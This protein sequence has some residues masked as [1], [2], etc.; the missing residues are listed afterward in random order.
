MS[1]TDFVNML[2]KHFPV[3]GQPLTIARHAGKRSHWLLNDNEALYNA[4]PDSRYGPKDIVYQFNSLG[5]RTDEFDQRRDV[6]VIVG[7]CSF[8]VGI[9]LPLEQTYPFILR[10]LLQ[11]EL[12]TSV[13]VWN[14]AAAAWG[15]D[16]IARIMMAA[17]KALKP[18]M[19]YV[20]WTDSSIRT[21][22]LAKG[23]SMGIGSFIF[24]KPEVV[25][26]FPDEL[27]PVIR[28]YK[29]LDNPVDRTVRAVRYG[30]ILH[31]YFATED[32]P[33]L[34]SCL[35]LPENFQ[36]DMITPIE[37]I[38]DPETFADVFMQ[39]SDFARDGQHPGPDTCQEY[40]AQ[41]APK[42]AARIKLKRA[43]E[44]Y[45]IPLSE[46]RQKE[47]LQVFQNLDLGDSEE[48]QILREALLAQKAIP[49]PDLP[50]T[51]MKGR[52]ASAWL[53]VDN[54]ESYQ[55]RTPSGYNSTDIEYRFNSHGYRCREF[56]DRGD[57][58]ILLLG[59]SETLGIGV[60]EEQTYAA[61]LEASLNERHDKSVR[62][63]NLGMTVCSNDTI[64]RLSM[65]AIPYFEPDAMHVTWCP[66]GR[67]EFFLSDGDSF[68]FNPNHHNKVDP[69]D[70]PENIRGVVS[71]FRTI[72]N[73]PQDYFNFLLNYL[74]V[75]FTAKSSNADFSCSLVNLPHRDVVQNHVADESLVA[76]LA[77]G[78]DRG[79]CGV[80]PG[81]DAHMQLANALADR[82]TDK[83]AR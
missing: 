37:Y 13:Q 6:N 66:P 51:N 9:G 2:S 24:D 21:H 27:Q 70:L 72:A 16:G 36:G 49:A 26:M 52:A 5:Y 67:R 63:W 48:D 29:R 59:G 54:L 62:V 32:I 83:I 75:F 8:T 42:I 31:H 50:A 11:T 55:N 19:A 15:D 28:A 1:Y 61:R 23:G 81:S 22:I 74:Q 34:F 65:L 78:I 60:A 14:M 38:V 77:Y 30:S 71:G 56:D 82:I 35:T 43:G 47:R 80:H 44:I 40:A 3:D 79:R 10:E 58:N 41:I 64:A 69:L 33:Y 68:V 45:A 7:G 12:G 57:I 17:T 18:D 20:H 4:K 73:D 76:W 39:L 25:A 53:G 46:E